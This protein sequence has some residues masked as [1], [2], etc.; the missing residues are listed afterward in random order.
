MLYDKGLVY[1]ESPDAPPVGGPYYRD[2]KAEFQTRVA[3]DGELEIADESVQISVPLFHAVDQSRLT[4]PQRD[5]LV[6]WLK[7]CKKDP[8]Q[9]EIVGL[10]SHGLELKPLLGEGHLIF[11]QQILL[12]FFRLGLKQSMHKHGAVSNIWLTGPLWKHS[13]G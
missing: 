6:Q 4:I 1:N 3:V 8:N 11:L 10:L 13:F 7:S 12:L 2:R 9:S 5:K